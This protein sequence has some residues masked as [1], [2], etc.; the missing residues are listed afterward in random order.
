[1]DSN[2]SLFSAYIGRNVIV[3][4]ADGDREKSIVGTV[5]SASQNFVR[6]VSCRGADLVLRT[7]SIVK[8]KSG[9]R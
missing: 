9:L 5:K 2:E 6:V 7:K 3:I 8:I 4:Y 1:M